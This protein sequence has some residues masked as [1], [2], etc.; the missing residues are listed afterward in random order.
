MACVGGCGYGA[1][2]QLFAFL[3]VATRRVWPA[4]WGK[5]TVHNILLLE[6]REPRRGK[7]QHIEKEGSFSWLHGARVR[8]TSKQYTPL[9]IRPKPRY[10]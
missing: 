3:H 10:I 1:H 8:K 5:E 4:K 2:H 7:E 6:L 9:H